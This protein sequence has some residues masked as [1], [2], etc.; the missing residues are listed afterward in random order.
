ME[1]RRSIIIF[2]P[3]SD[4]RLLISQAIDSAKE[5]I[6]HCSSSTQIIATCQQERPSLVIILGI[7]PFIDGSHLIEQIRPKGSRL[8]LIYVVA[9]QQSEHAILSL[10]ESGVNQYM[11]F[12]ICMQRLRSKISAINEQI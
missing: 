4:L 7:K 1:Q 11:T 8:P 10:L 6:I 12:P 2:S 9:W 3:Q 5:R